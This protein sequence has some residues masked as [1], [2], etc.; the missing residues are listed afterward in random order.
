MGALFLKH[1]KEKFATVTVTFTVNQVIITTE[2]NSYVVPRWFCTVAMVIFYSLLQEPG[3]ITIIRNAWYSI[4]TIPNI[5]ILAFPYLNDF[6]EKCDMSSL[7]EVTKLIKLEVMLD[8][9]GLLPW[10]F[11]FVI[12][13]LPTAGLLCV[14]L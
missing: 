11:T 4:M 13:V 12:Y 5:L 1:F 6:K 14:I 8:T 9:R 3:R 2:P 7:K 10:F